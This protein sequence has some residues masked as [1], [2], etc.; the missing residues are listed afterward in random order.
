RRREAAV[1]SRD[2]SELGRQRIAGIE[3]VRLLGL[4]VRTQM[5]QKERDQRLVRRGAL[6]RRALELREQSGLAVAALGIG[7][8]PFGVVEIVVGAE[9]LESRFAELLLLAGVG[10]PAVIGAQALEVVDVA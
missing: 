4:L 6:L 9:H 7:E 5:R 3:D 1:V 10:E 8:L 2:R